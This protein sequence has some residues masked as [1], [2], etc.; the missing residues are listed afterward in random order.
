MNLRYIKIKLSKSYLK[1]LMLTAMILPMT[2]QAGLI[3]NGDFSAGGTDWTITGGCTNAAY[4]ISGGAA[5]GNP[6]PSLRLNSCGET[7]SDPLAQQIV[8][9]LTIG[10]L[11]ELS[12]DY[13]FDHGGGGGAGTSFGVFLDGAVL[14][15]SEH[16]TYSF[17]NRSLSFM[18]T[19]TTHVLGFAAE[20]DARTLGV[21]V[22]SDRSYYLDNVSLTSAAPV[23]EPSTL[24]IFAL[25]IMGL[26]SRRF[27]K[28]A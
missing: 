22:S 1:L 2:A 11:Y 18:A 15:L 12:W 28:Q 4:M 7:N 9:G 5:V 21:S 19:S 23:P 14:D 20:L 27:K 6:G 3:T 13:K 26:S 8:S 16:F 10:A 25:G 24:A 17:V